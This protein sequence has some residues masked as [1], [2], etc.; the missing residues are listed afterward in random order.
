MKTWSWTAALQTK[1]CGWSCSHAGLAAQAAP[2]AGQPACIA[3]TVDTQAASAAAEPAANQLATQPRPCGMALLGALVTLCRAQ[4]SASGA[5]AKPCCVAV[6][7]WMSQP[8]RTSG[9]DVS[10][11][12]ASSC[13]ASGKAAMICGW[14]CC[15][16]ELRP[17]PRP[18]VLDK[19]LGGGD[20]SRRM[21]RTSLP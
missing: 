7:T 21:T 17:M 14:A 2:T 4:A 6:C 5:D 20:G 18:Q 12:L 15:L 1:L 19:S 11:M 9:L 3:L 10:Q 8:S 16:L 13:P